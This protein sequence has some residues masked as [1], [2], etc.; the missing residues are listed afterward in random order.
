MNGKSNVLVLKDG[1][2]EQRVL[3]VAQDEQDGRIPVLRGVEL[4][5]RVVAAYDPSLRNGQP[6]TSGPSGASA[7]PATNA[8][9]APAAQAAPAT[10][11]APAAQAAP[12]EQ[13]ETS[14][15]P[16]N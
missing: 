15:Q 6:A 13:P 12:S 9:P 10:Q 2:L 11:P 8:P 4:G 3:Q 14:G 7:K 1:R 16:A 5:E